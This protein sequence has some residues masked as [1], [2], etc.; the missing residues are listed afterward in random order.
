V[1]PPVGR[2]RLQ[3]DEPM[4]VGLN[5]GWLGRRRDLIPVQA[6]SHC[7]RTYFLALARAAS[8][9]SVAS[10]STVSQPE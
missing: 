4:T 7:V 1:T 2:A 8:G 9:L 3:S 5:G 6:S 10:D